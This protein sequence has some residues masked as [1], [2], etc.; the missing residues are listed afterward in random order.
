MLCDENGEDIEILQMYRLQD[1]AAEKRI[2]WPTITKDQ[3]E[4]RSK[5]DAFS[6]AFAL[7]QTTWFIIQ[8]IA[9]GVTGLVITELELA[10]LAFAFLNG[11]LYFLWWDKPIDVACPVP[12]HL[13]PSKSEFG[14]QST[15]SE[16][17][18][19]PDRKI[20]LI[21]SDSPTP[22]LALQPFKYE[23][24]EF[25]DEGDLSATKLEANNLQLAQ[26]PPIALHQP[27]ALVRFAGDAM[28][29]VLLP[30]RM[31]WSPV[32]LMAAQYHIPPSDRPPLSV[33]MFYAPCPVNFL[34]PSAIAMAVGIIFG[35]IHCI[36]WR[37]EFISVEERWLWRS[38]ALTITGVP[39]LAATV[40]SIVTNPFMGRFR[41][42]FELIMGGWIE[43]L[44]VAAYFIARLFL[45]IL[46]LIALRR[47]PAKA[48]LDVDWSSYLPHI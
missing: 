30:F 24:D 20:S 25:S 33:P 8:I 27:S 4:D 11:I 31:F 19:L 15:D 13:M 48:L 34:Q 5:G 32:K 9:R 22:N 47:L 29:T 1:L 43:T 3:I 36:A 17:G 37:F 12:V 6:K 18:E 16:H 38:S 42:I 39:L 35:G 10:T 7:I 23:D 41:L 44:C 28:D 26:N 2:V 46:P 40:L 45:L 21:L 14:M